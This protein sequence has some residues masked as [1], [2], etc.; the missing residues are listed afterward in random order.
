MQQ[1]DNME[2]EQAEQQPKEEYDGYEQEW[3]QDEGEEELREP[4]LDDFGKWKMD[5]FKAFARDVLIQP[6]NTTKTQSQTKGTNEK[7]EEQGTQLTADMGLQN[8][9]LY[10]QPELEQTLEEENIGTSVYQ[11]ND[12]VQAY[13]ELKKCMVKA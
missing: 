10:P 6:A 9:D 1:Q 13:K 8:T 5:K 4:S 11:G 12:I 2:D 3:T 7:P